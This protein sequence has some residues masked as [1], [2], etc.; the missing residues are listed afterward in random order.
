[1]KRS[2]PTYS[3]TRAAPVT[4]ANVTDEGDTL[5]VVWS[6]GASVERSGFFAGRWIE[7]LSLDRGAVRLDRLNA[8]GPL[9]D[10]HDQYQCAALVGSIVPGSVRIADGQASAQVRL[11]SAADAADTVA[12]V[13]EGHL[14][15]ISVGYHVHVWDVRDGPDDVP[16]YLAVDWEPL[17]ISLVTVPADTGAHVRAGDDDMTRIIDN[18][19]GARGPNRGERNQAGGDEPPPS[20]P[21]PARRKPP[22]RRRTTATPPASA[23]RPGAHPAA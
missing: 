13:R 19:R 5:E 23:R 11:S 7:T 6:T 1:M 15:G 2:L 8:G 14:W 18:R 4:R 22:R 9:L 3:A 20:G 21:A 16:E 12:K 10:S 17:E